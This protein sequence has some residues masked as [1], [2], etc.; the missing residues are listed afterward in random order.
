ME[1]ARSEFLVCVDSSQ[2]PVSLERRKIHR[3]AKREAGDPAS[4]VRIVDESGEDY[5]YP[6]SWFMPIDLPPK[7]V[8]AISR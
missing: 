7:L 1:R 6:R 2:M 4:M 8:A 3:L 5:L